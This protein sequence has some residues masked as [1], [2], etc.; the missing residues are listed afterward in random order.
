MTFGVKLL[1]LW[2]GVSTA[3]AIIFFPMP[4]LQV[5]MIAGY[6]PIVAYGANYL[7]VRYRKQKSGV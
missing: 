5:V 6:F 4:R 3:I 2:A 1:L 7:F